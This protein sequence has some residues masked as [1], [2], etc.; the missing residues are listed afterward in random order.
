MSKSDLSRRSILAGAVASLAAPAIAQT[1]PARPI[2]LVVPFAAGG[3]T[4]VV[5]RI[6][7]QS[8]SEA[9]GQSVV[10]E[11][12]AGA[13]GNIGA[14][15]V[16]R[17]EPDGYTILMGTISTHTLNPIMAKTRPF[18][19]VAGFTPISLLANIPNVLVVHPSLGVSTVQEL[20]ALL[21]KEPDKHNYAS[22][23][24][25]TPLHVSGEL[26]KRMTGTQM[27]HIPYR[28][29]GPAMNDLVGGQVKIM[30]DNL[31]SSAPHIRGGTIRA[32][33][34]TVKERIPGFDIPSM[35]EAGLPDY[36]TYSWNALFGPPGLPQA[37]V[38]RLNEAGNRAVRNPAVAARLSE[39]SAVPV[40]STPDQLAEHVKAQLATW[41]PVIKAA[42]ITLD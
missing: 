32:L 19:P 3:S 34:V 30:F 10:V 39:L 1:Y 21:K 31:P 35:R 29:A 36:E 40:G 13:G 33:A 7:A 14:T 24:I 37:V 11:N 8:M 38:A 9:L 28:G 4:D 5:A 42:N 18:D 22:S 2:S 16:S 41:E 23:G 25:G 20:I 12:R 6:V 27:Q 17:A 15:S 26:F